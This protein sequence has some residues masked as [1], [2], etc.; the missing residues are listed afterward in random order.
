MFLIVSCDE[1][2]SN[3]V[4]RT[5]ISDFSLIGTWV[6][7]IDTVWRVQVN[8]FE[9][10]CDTNYIPYKPSNY[11]DTITFVDSIHCITGAA[12][13]DTQTYWFEDTLST[14]YFVIRGLEDHK[15]MGQTTFPFEMIGSCTSTQKLIEVYMI[16]GKL[17]LQENGRYAVH[18]ELT[19]GDC[20]EVLINGKW[21]KTRI[22]SSRGEYYLVND[23]PIDGATIRIRDGDE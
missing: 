13:K 10:Y 3:P 2:S 7:V 18:Y 15:W 9:N 22:E 11:W 17:F 20:V 14:R 1:K 4:A 16:Q 8:L 19:S 6:N 12:L 23:F 5:E 21:V